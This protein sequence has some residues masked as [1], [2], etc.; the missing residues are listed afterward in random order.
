MVRPD[1]RAGESTAARIP[2]EER[3]AS[4]GCPF[5][6][7]KPMSRQWRGARASGDSAGVLVRYGR[8][9]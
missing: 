4:P 5:R 1:P 2:L 9:P 8:D 7:G 3:S 6:C